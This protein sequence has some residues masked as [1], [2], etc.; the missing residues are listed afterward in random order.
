MDVDRRTIGYIVWFIALLSSVA[1]LVES[2]T[3]RRRF[4]STYL[5]PIAIAGGIASPFL[6]GRTSR[7]R[8]PLVVGAAAGVV[9]VIIALGIWAAHRN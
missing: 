8:W 4:V 2:L 5:A 9:A 3:V 7:S 6:I 1:W